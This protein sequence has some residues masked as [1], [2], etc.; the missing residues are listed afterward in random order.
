MRKLEEDR[1]KE[2]WKKQWKYDIHNNGKPI[3][4]SFERWLKWTRKDEDFLSIPSDEEE[5]ANPDTPDLFTI[6][7]KGI[8]GR[9]SHQ[10]FFQRIQDTLHMSLI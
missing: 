8:S 7:T 1:L 10:R 4:I 2:E 6:D 5:I 3:H 9:N